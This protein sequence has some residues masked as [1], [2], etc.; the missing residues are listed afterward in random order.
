MSEEAPCPLPA[1]FVGVVTDYV[2]KTLI[3]ANDILKILEANKGKIF[4]AG[5]LA[6]ELPKEHSLEQIRDAMWLLDQ[7]GEAKLWVR[8][9]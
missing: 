4:T 9:P 5:E 7:Q 2:E 1:G 3:L 6:R 8:L